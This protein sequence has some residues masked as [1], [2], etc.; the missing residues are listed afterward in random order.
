MCCKSLAIITAILFLLTPNLFLFAETHITI[1]NL[2]VDPYLGKLINY[3]YRAGAIDRQGVAYQNVRSKKKFDIWYQQICWYA[4]IAGIGKGRKADIELGMK[5]IEY[6]FGKMQE[7]G[8]FENSTA[9]G[10]IRFLSAFAKSYYEIAKSKYKEEYINRLNLHI[11]K[12]KK[13]TYGILNSPQWKIE[14]TEI[15][16]YSNQIIGIGLTF[17]LL[18]TILDD[19]EVARY[20]EELFYQALDK[21]TKEGVF[22]EKNGYDSSYQAVSL[23]F[24]ELYYIYAAGDEEKLSLFTKLKKGW[25]WELARIKESGEIEVTGNTRTGLKQEKWRGEFKN[26][27]YMEVALS[28]IYWAHIAEDKRSRE[29]AR[30]IFEYGL[31]K[32]AT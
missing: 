24:I 15:L 21:Q 18:G 8:S 22:P 13:A 2:L 10:S 29:L 17:K 4:I 9:T 20:G 30:T 16:D 32:K 3:Y 14:K 7:D 12:L 19:Q 1:D 28:L 25:E 6:G 26:V 31:R 11:P 23:Q 5:A 27:N